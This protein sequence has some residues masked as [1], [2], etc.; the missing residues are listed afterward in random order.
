ML[1]YHSSLLS[2][3]L[4]VSIGFPHLTRCFSRT[5]TLQIVVRPGDLHVARRMMKRALETFRPAITSVTKWQ[6]IRQHFCNKFCPT[7]RTLDPAEIEGSFLAFKKMQQNDEET[8]RDHLVNFLKI[9]LPNLGRGE[10]LD[11]V[12]QYLNTSAKF[13]RCKVRRV[14][15]GGIMA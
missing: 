3:S 6:A 9:R 14:N 13:V 12:Q 4:H 8:N 15:V 5:T 11:V 1:C 10:E 2:C 7:V